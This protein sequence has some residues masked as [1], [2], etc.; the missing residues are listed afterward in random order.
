ML[1]WKDP[2][3]GLWLVPVDGA[4]DARKIVTGWWGALTPDERDVAYL[5]VRRPTDCDISRNPIEGGSPSIVVK[6]LMG[7]A[8]TRFGISPDGNFLL[9][10]SSRVGSYDL[11][12]TRYPSGEGRWPLPHGNGLRGFWSRDGQTLY[13]ASDNR[14]M[15]AA[16]AESPAVSIG[17]PR[18]LVDGTPLNLNLDR[19]FQLLSD[20]T[21]IAV[22]DLPPDKRQIVL[23][24]NWFAEF[25]EDEK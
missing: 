6:S 3:F 16:F 20:G 12:L 24:Q 10:A 13:F 21:V 7:S 1:N 22:Q 11:I 8:R 5:R 2:L 15:A 4:G 14:V 25:R 23:V 18:M 9:Y 17:K 19:G